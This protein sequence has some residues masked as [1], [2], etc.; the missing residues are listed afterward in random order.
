MISYTGDNAPFASEG[1]KRAYREHTVRETDNSVEKITIMDL[2]KQKHKEWNAQG[3]Q[4]LC[5]EPDWCAASFMIWLEKIEQSS[6]T[7]RKRKNTKSE[8]E[9]ERRK[10]DVQAEM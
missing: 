8:N 10:N 7:V 1:L 6:Q 9:P 4:I 2:K 5:E 3:T